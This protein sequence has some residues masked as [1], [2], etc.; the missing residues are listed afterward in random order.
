MNV[1]CKRDVNIIY[2]PSNVEDLPSDVEHPLSCCR[3]YAVDIGWCCAVSLSQLVTYESHES[4]LVAFASVRHR[5]HIRRISL[6][7]YAVER[8]DSG[9]R[10][11][12]IALLKGRNTTYAKNKLVKGKQL[13]GLMFVAGEAMEH[14]AYEVMFV[15][16]Q[17]LDHLILSLT[18]MYHQRQLC[19]YRPLHLCR[20]GFHLLM[21]ELTRP[22]VVKSDLTDG[23]EPPSNSPEGE[24]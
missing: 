4:R 11:W 13:L 6:Q 7:H 14:T 18:A 12:Q 21:F 8:Y 2:T 10:R 19:F 1:L 9:Q 3:C 16:T 22:V 20:E 5:C 23:N 17:H 24:R 15:V